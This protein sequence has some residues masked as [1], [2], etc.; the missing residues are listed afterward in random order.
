M[1]RMLFL[2]L[3]LTALGAQTPANTAIYA[4]SYVDVMPA[5]RAAAV[6]AFKQY[7]DMSRK[8]EGYLRFELFEQPSRPG[9]FAI[10]ESWANQ[11]AFDAHQVASS[12]KEWR[13]K[14]DPIRLSDYDQRPYKNLSAGSSAAAANDR[15]V[16]VIAHVDIGGQGAQSFDLAVHHCRIFHGDPL[17]CGAGLGNQRI[18]A[19]DNAADLAF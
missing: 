17:I 3:T 1:R 5:S 8:D 12:A 14:L 13:S 15:S 2:L 4:V 19:P 11:N 18:H 7:R 9:H 6:T 16:Y 10:I